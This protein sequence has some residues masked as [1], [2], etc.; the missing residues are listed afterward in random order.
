MLVCLS[1]ILKSTG[2]RNAGHCHLFPL[3]R[4]PVHMQ[5]VPPSLADSP[6]VCIECAGGFRHEVC[7]STIRPFRGRP[8]VWL[9]PACVVRRCRAS[10]HPK[11][12]SGCGGNLGGTPYSPAT[13]TEKKRAVEQSNVNAT[14]L[15]WLDGAGDFDQLRAATSGS[16]NGRSVVYLFKLLPFSPLAG[17]PRRRRIARRD[18]GGAQRDQMAALVRIAPD[19]EQPLQRM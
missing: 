15:R 8:M 7:L 19:L 4:T 13:K 12:I 16:T 2:V 17:P 10:G 18:L 11:F 9:G 3:I 6:A 1:A 5:F 14:L